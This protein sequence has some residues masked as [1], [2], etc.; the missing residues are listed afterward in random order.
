[1]DK[2]RHVVAL[3]VSCSSAETDLK[4]LGEL[5]T[6]LRPLELDGLLQLSHRR[7][8]GPG[9]DVAQRQAEALEAAHL[10]LLLISSDYRNDDACV[11]ESRRALARRDAGE[12]RV[13]PVLLR[14]CD[15]KHGPLAGLKPLPGNELPVSS[16]TDRDAAWENVARSVRV[17]AEELRPDV[18]DRRD[19]AANVAH[20]SRPE[21]EQGDRLLEQTIDFLQRVLAVLELRERQRGREVRII[22][23]PAPP[24]FHEHVEVFS[25]ERLG[26]S[27]TFALGVSAESITEESLDLFRRE[28]HTPYTRSA[29]G[30]F[31]QLVYG[32]DAAP[33]SLVN[34]AYFD[35]IHLTSFLEYQGLIDFRRY[36]EKQ[37]GDLA[38]DRVYPPSL[39]V[40]QRF[41]HTVGLD[42]HEG[43][44]ALAMLQDW[45]ASPHA[46]FVLVLGDFGTGKTFLLREL[47]RRLG[48]RGGPLAPLLI[49]MRGLQK[50][51]RLGELVAQHLMRCGMDRIDYPAFQYMLS[52]GRIVLLFDGFDELALRVSYERATEHFDTLLEAATGNAKIVV[53]SRT[54]HFISEQQ[55]KTALGEKAISRGFRLMTLQPFDQAQIRRFLTNR[56]SSEQIAEQRLRL[57]EQVRDLLGLS[58]NPRMLSFI[59]EIEEEKLLEARGASGEITA[60]GLYQLLLDR[61][62]GHEF[63]RAHPKGM[64][65]GLSLAQRWAA[66]VELA[67]LLWRRTERT[68]HVTEIPESI[69]ESVKTLAAA[70]RG[71]PPQT[72]E[73]GVI[74][75]QL[76]SGT[77]LRRDEEGNCS[78]LHQ[79]ILE[80]LVAR[81]AAREVEVG[82]TS[83]LLAAAEMPLLMAEFFASLATPTRA[84]TWARGILEAEGAGEVA[85]KNALLVLRHLGVEARRGLNLAGQDLRG[86]DLSGRDL[87]RADLTGADLTDARLVGARLDGASLRQARLVRADLSKASAVGVNFEGADLSMARLLGTDLRQARFDGAR[88]SMM[89]RLV[90][91]SLDAGAIGERDLALAAPPIPPIVEARS[92]SPAA[93][94]AAAAFSPEGALMASGHADGSVRLWE[95]RSGQPIRA[96]LGHQDEVRSVAFSPDSRTLASGSTDQTLRLWDVGTGEVIHVLRSHK[97]ALTSVA[98]S[99]DGQVLASGSKDRSVRLWDARSG[100][101]LHELRGHEA[102]VTSVAFSSDGRTLASG[103]NDRTVRLWDTGTGAATGLL[104]HQ[105]MVTSV[106]FSPDGSMVAFGTDDRSVLLQAVGHRKMRLNLQGHSGV[107]TSVAFSPGGQILASGSE[108]MTVRLWDV[109]SGRQLHALQ[110]HQG[111]VSSV[112]FS[113]DGRT[114]ASASKD[115]TLRLWDATSGQALLTT[116]GHRAPV[117]NVAFSQDGLTLALGTNGPAVRLWDLSSGLAERVLQGFKDGVLGVAFRPEGGIMVAC[118]V[119]GDVRLWEPGSNSPRH[120][121]HSQ[122][123]RMHV[124][125]AAFSLDGRTVALGGNDGSLHLWAASSGRLLCKLE[126]HLTWVTWVSFSSDGNTLASASH[127]RTVR[128]WRVRSGKSLRVIEGHEDVVTSVALS[129]D[130]ELVASGSGDRTLRV[131]ETQSGRETRLSRHDAVLRCMSFSPPRAPRDWTLAAGAD[132]G[133]VLLYDRGMENPQLL[134]GH[135]ARVSGV[136]F[137]PDGLLLASASHDGTARLWHVATGACL[138]VLLPRPEGWAAFTLDGR[139][140]LGGDIQGAFWHLVGPCR[141]EPGELDPYLPEPLRVPDDQPL[142]TLPPAS[143]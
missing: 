66:V 125:S 82:G 51:Q 57:I 99:P 110:G 40:P 21:G 129:A 71:G 37:T 86:Q 118:G 9:E 87:E 83:A 128:L 33:Q 137:S 3:M 13:I 131:W 1:M 26:Q 14:P 56:F 112:T 24:P 135:E 19:N 141:F 35:G 2:R 5:E 127:D 22:R 116:Q 65:P 8:V 88:L 94:C 55:V 10:I 58:H 47:A 106:A 143:S 101:L 124:R 46:R 89:V 108:D 32:G 38:A 73:D 105:A 113:P 93:P 96:L 91:A 104:T 114:A 41:R 111:F 77:L 123:Q 42:E 132:D 27:V 107:V 70:E 44:D 95:A 29:P 36:I 133:A 53:T 18:A 119:D 115:R 43:D 49:E 48:H 25:A 45:L 69:L 90:G 109:T 7:R 85:I 23:K 97:A 142:F 138:A 102:W 84:V 60:A 59:A 126:G 120:V 122:R 63:E 52:E 80:W 62:L 76:G 75:H 34:R 54:Q 20:A 130:G 100:G 103:G 92:D 15:W 50:A 139:F 121:L 68:I 117:T 17:I 39:F 16:W 12:V 98:F 134:R 6:H 81:E 11:D 61:W 30:V 136:A 72:L 28:V 140:K 78:F 31:S 79:S 67:A 64:Q 74:A 4:L